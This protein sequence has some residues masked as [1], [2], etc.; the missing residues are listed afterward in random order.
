M[1]P[2]QRS[3]VK[4]SAGSRAAASV[5]VGRKTA[6]EAERDAVAASLQRAMEAERA[7]KAGQAGP[8][9]GRQLRLARAEPLVPQPHADAPHV[10]LPERSE[11]H[12]SK[13]IDAAAQSAAAAASSFPVVPSTSHVVRQSVALRS[14]PTR[15]RAAASATSAAPLEEA[16]AAVASPSK[17]KAAGKRRRSAAPTVDDRLEA[18]AAPAATDDTAAASAP[19]AAA[20]AVAVAPVLESHLHPAL[21]LA[22]LFR[23]HWQRRRAVVPLSSLFPYCAPAHSLVIPFNLGEPVALPPASAAAA[24]EVAARA[25]APSALPASPVAAPVPAVARPSKKQKRVRGHDAALLSSLDQLADGGDSVNTMSFE[26]EQQQQQQRKPAAPAMEGATRVAPSAATAVAAAAPSVSSEPFSSVSSDFNLDDVD[27]AEETLRESTPV[28]LRKL[29]DMLHVRVDM[30]P[31]EESDF[32][33]LT[34]NH[35]WRQ[36]FKL[37]LLQYWMQ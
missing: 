8:S 16:P 18:A 12:P 15:R 1:L 21:A 13:W 37:K 32:Q 36:Q 29:A 14:S 24:P 35:E 30:T 26:G 11:L 28:V 5:Y 4:S 31:A 9:G 7:A 23:T 25:V 34:K 17:V 33:L 2:L 3:N 22:N 6:A 27:R 20:A 19:A 10:S